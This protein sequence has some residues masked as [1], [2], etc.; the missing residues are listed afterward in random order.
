CMLT[1]FGIHLQFQ[2][3]KLT[4]RRDDTIELR[5]FMVSKRCLCIYFLFHFSFFF[6]FY[7]LLFINLIPKFVSNKIASTYPILNDLFEFLNKFITNVSILYS[8]IPGSGI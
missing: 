8:K 2:P 3:I 6:F 4:K 5:I 1:E 7:F